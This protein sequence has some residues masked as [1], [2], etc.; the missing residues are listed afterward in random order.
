MGGM[1]SGGRDHQRPTSEVAESFPH[2]QQRVVVPW[3]TFSFGLSYL[4]ASSFSS[5][6]VLPQ[7]QARASTLFP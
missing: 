7:E 6:P 3:P 1:A 2:L 5:P 4:P